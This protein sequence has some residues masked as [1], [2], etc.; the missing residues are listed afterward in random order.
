MVCKFWATSHRIIQNSHFVAYY[1]TLGICT[2]LT[3][4]TGLAESTGVI[5]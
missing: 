2:L 1:A 3:R 4:R 5:L